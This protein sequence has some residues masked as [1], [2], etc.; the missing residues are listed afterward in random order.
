MQ[1]LEVTPIP[2]QCKTC[3][4]KECYNCDVAGKRWVLSRQ[5]QL[6]TSRTLK[7]KAICRLQREVEEIDKELRKLASE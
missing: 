4:E 2:E 6:R 3:R 5:D 7:Q 1:W